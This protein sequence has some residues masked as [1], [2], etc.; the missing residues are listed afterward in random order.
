MSWSQYQ[1][2][3]SDRF[4]QKPEQPDDPIKSLLGVGSVIAI[5]AFVTSFLPGALAL[6]MLEGMLFW[7]S[8][9]YM[10]RAFMR[11]ER[12]TRDRLNSWDQALLVLAASIAVG[13]FVDPSAIEAL[14]AQGAG[15][16]S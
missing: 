10:T 2:P 4:G 13:L 3:D 15:T 11:G 6:L 16:P 12:W 1:Q 5:C 9:G 14:A 8:L 7:A